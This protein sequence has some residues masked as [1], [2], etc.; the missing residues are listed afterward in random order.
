MRRVQQSALFVGSSRSLPDD[1]EALR[2]E[3]ALLLFEASR[4]AVFEGYSFY[5]TQHWQ[6]TAHGGDE[7]PDLKRAK[8]WN[9][10]DESDL[11]S[12]FPLSCIVSVFCE[13]DRAGG[14]D[15]RCSREVAR[16]NLDETFARWPLT[17]MLR[18]AGL[19]IP[20]LVAGLWVACVLA[21]F[22]CR[23]TSLLVVYLPMAYFSCFLFR[24]VDTPT[25]PLVRVLGIVLHAAVPL[26]CILRSADFVSAVWGEEGQLHPA[27]ETILRWSQRNNFKLVCLW[28]F[29]TGCLVIW[30]R[31]V[32]ARREHQERFAAQRLERTATSEKEKAGAKMADGQKFDVPAPPTVVRPEPEAAYTDVAADNLCTG[33]LGGAS[34]AVCPDV[35]NGDGRCIGASFSSGGVDAD[36]SAADAQP[37]CRICLGDREAG[38]LI[39]PCMCSGTL[40]FVHVECL[41]MWRMASANPRSFYQCDQ[42][43]YR[44]SFNRAVYASILRSAVV[45]HSLTLVTFLGT[46]LCCSYI[47][48]IADRH[49]VNISSGLVSDTVLEQL[50]NESDVQL[51][52]LK[53]GISTFNDIAWNG[54]HL[55]HFICGILMVGV[56]G[57]VS[58][59]FLWFPF[60]GGPGHRGA[61]GPVI[62]IAVIIGAIRVMCG[63]YGVFKNTSGRLLQSA[64]NMILEVGT[65]LDAS[66]PPRPS[67][68]DVLAGG[69]V[70]AVADSGMGKCGGDDNASPKPGAS[71]DQPREM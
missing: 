51:E 33:D 55:V 2:T 69:D 53:E 70:V 11:R 9:R 61:E 68:I 41:N 67:D 46:V 40:R 5:H 58:M 71:S 8:V 3:H 62:I 60:L 47:A 43:Q 52:T 66:Y 39:S 26:T 48:L 63:I 20:V 31:A 15:W 7:K 65:G 22:A 30:M 56:T 35:D 6:Y 44:Y 13:E 24:H 10:Y 36:R 28:A 17:N 54:I 23:I 49:F 14:H 1:M 4:F 32:N 25:V 34:T 16:R 50:A 29:C 19:L 21:T 38:R 64:E 37:M 45:L 12:Y 18:Y 59:G 57:L 42:C 27:L